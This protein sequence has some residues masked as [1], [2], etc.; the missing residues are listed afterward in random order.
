MRRGLAHYTP[1]EL[2]NIALGHVRTADG[3]SLTIDRF[4]FCE[5]GVCTRCGARQPVA[6]FIAALRGAGKCAAC[7]AAVDGS[8]FNAHRPTPLSVMGKSAD[9][10]LHEIVDRSPEAIVVRGPNEAVLCEY[11]GSN[12]SNI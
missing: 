11:S 1:R 6:R 4:Q 9:R 7:G 12:G 3:I 5:A 8:P 2:A 10:P